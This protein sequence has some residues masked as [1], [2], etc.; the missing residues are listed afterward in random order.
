[1]KECCLARARAGQGGWGRLWGQALQ[2]GVR[3]GILAWKED[4]VRAKGP[5]SLPK[6]AGQGGARAGQAGPP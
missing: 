1:M 2:S 3:T 6:A 4:G 5:L